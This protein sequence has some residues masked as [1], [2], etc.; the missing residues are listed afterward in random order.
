M[1]DWIKNIGKEVPEFW[2]IYSAKFDTKSE[3]FVIISC[4]TS[5]LNAQK[6]TILAVAGIAVIN[7]A[8]VINDSFEI[9]INYDTTV[10]DHSVTSDWTELNP[11]LALQEVVNFIGNAKLIG[12][13]I[14][15]ETEIINEMLS[16]L[17]CG[18]LKNE[19]F[20]LEVMHKK[21]E[22]SIDDNFTLSEL[23]SIYNIQQS[24]RATAAIEAFNMALL[25]LKLKSR[26]N[27]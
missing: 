18:K 23:F 8:I 17:H 12:F 9:K 10:A 26:L 25:F 7:D 6:D 20:D 1:F 13:R 22:N 15:F 24:D 16:K 5:G 19:V 3:R 4:E 14:N 11:I 27:I 21:Y 2:K